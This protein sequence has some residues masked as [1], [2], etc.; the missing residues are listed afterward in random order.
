MGKRKAQQDSFAGIPARERQ[1]VKTWVHVLSIKGRRV[2]P[3][4]AWDEIQKARAR[5]KEDERA[6]QREREKENAEYKKRCIADSLRK[7]AHIRDFLQRIEDG[8]EDGPESAMFARATLIEA[9]MEMEQALFDLRL[10][11]GLYGRRGEREGWFVE[12]L[13]KLPK[14]NQAAA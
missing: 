1:N 5:D 13:G 11:D 12:S 3:R 9:C 8:E 14:A 10:T 4:K 7:F 6:K 2:S